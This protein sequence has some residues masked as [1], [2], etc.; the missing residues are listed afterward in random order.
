MGENGRRRCLP[1]LSAEVRAE[2]ERL[3]RYPGATAGGI[4]TTEFVRLIRHEVGEA[5]SHIRA[6]AREKESIYACYVMDAGT[7]A[8]W[9]PSRCATW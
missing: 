4:M 7:G 8:C 3:L 1:K 6:V 2:V 9:A 5:L